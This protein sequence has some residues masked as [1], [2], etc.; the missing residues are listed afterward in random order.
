MTPPLNLP[1]ALVR[2]L[3]RLSR[4]ASGLEAPW[5]MFGS[6]AMRLI[7]AADIEAEDVDLL[8]GRADAERLAQRLGATRIEGAGERFRSAYFA[9][10]QTEDLRIEIMS[11]L[12]VRTAEGWRRVSPR[13]QALVAWEPCPLPLPDRGELIEICRLFGRPKDLERAAKLEQLSG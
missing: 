7:G 8:L 11:G 1:A 3:D 6:A 9:K 2:T 5:W 13:T 4:E 12:E 10:A